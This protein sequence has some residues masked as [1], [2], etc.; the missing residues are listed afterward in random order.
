MPRGNVQP[1]KSL[2]PLG[3][4]LWQHVQ[5]DYG[6]EDADGLALLQ[7]ACV[8]R[9]LEASAM[10]TVAREGLCSVDRYGQRRAHPLLATARDA[11]SSMMMAKTR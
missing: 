3:H 5:A 2:G 11:R 4:D 8:C 10:D 9:E 6:I 1:P 7:T